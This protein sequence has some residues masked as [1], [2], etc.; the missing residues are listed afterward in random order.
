MKHAH[1][2]KEVAGKAVDK[3]PVCGMDVSPDTAKHTHVHDE[4]TYYFCSAGCLEKFKKA[5]DD[6]LKPQESESDP[7]DSARTYTCPMH[8]EVT[9]Q[10]PGSCPKC[11]MALEP[12]DGDGGEEDTTELDGMK[13]RL[14][15][16]V[17]LTVPI[18]IIAMGAM[19]PGLEDVF[20]PPWWRWVELVLATPVVL[21]CG[22]VFFQRGWQSVLNRSPNMFT[23]I[24]LGTGVAYVYSLVAAIAPG[25]FPSSFQDDLGHV[26]LYF[27]SAAVIITL[28]LVGQVLELKARSQ[29]AGAIRALLE[30]APR[31]ARRIRE[32]GEEE[33]VPL[34]EVVEGDRLRVRPGERI[35]VDGVIDEGESSVDESMITGEAMA[36]KKSAD[37]SVTGGTVNGNGSFIMHAERVGKD[38]TL[39]RIVDM[40]KQ[41]QRSRA[42]IQ[43]VADTVAGYFV[44]AVL[45]ISVITFVVWMLLGPSPAIAYALVN[46]IAVLIIACPCALGLATPISIMVGTGR[47]AQAGVLLRSA[48]SLEAM[49]RVDVLVVDKTGTLTEGRPRVVTVEVESG[50]SED[51]VVRFA[52]ALERGSEHPL[53]AA[54]LAEAKERDLSLAD[55][56]DFE[57]V[58]GKGVTG[59]IDGK[60]VLLGNGALLADHGVDTASLVDRA[61]ALREKAQTAVLLAVDGK[62]VGVLG[63]ADPIKESTPDALKALRAD[64]LRIVMLTGDSETTANAVARELGIDEVH[65]GVM[66]EEKL[67]HIKDLQ[68][69]GA[70]VAMAGDGTNDAPALAQ[71]EVGIAMGSGTDVAMESA[72]ITLVKGDL[73]GIVRARHLSRATM[74]NI[75]QNLFFA[76]AYNALGIPLAAG[77]LY[78]VFG[79]LL[80][81]MI[82]AAAMSLSSV[83]VVGNALRLRNIDL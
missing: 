49:E 35:P 46:S 34:D 53:A 22:G 68:A 30:L 63:I 80:S 1:A 52:G 41:A 16:G 5:P 37:D 36:V 13:R 45:V 67:Q 70:T 21:W 8:P 74:R 28:V 48:E 12:A 78:P 38:T 42:P 65:A 83:S 50:H 25:L 4:T 40:V 11:G 59:I 55:A 31:S 54:I 9:Q 14:W 39:A 3:D 24:A 6:Y 71:A 17:V 82:A 23:L 64:G 47:G 73:S 56:Q 51:D 7:A 79:L 76:F 10:G 58:T 26:A 33:D 62:P 77:I 18:F 69:G 75:R 27:E 43:Q 44:P 29:T 60:K 2:E 66:P 15:V 57:A 72:G 32:D 20:A 19:V 81:P 61:E